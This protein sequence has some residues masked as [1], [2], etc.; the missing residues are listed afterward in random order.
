MIELSICI[1]SACNVNGARSVI[2]TFKKLIEEKNLQDKIN[3]SASFCM[4][5]CHNRGV[6]VRLNSEAT[7]I[8]ADSAEAYFNKKVVPLTEA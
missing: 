7:N 8:T 2:T 6:S 5:Q 3:L 1:G 4:K